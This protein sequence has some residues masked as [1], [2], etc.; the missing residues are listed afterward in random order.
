MDNIHAILKQKLYNLTTNKLN[1]CSSTQPSCLSA[2]MSSKVM[3]TLS[4]HGS[5]Q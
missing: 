1:A 5:V 2:F 4:V 3:K